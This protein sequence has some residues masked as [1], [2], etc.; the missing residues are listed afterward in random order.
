MDKKIL[1][2]IYDQKAK[3][4]GFIQTHDHLIDA[5]RT[6]NHMIAADP[7]SPIARYPQDFSM[8]QVGTMDISTGI[9]TPIDPPHLVGHIADLLDSQES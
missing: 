2:N 1:I 8:F 5:Q 4:F 9:P 7:K 6:L 3:R